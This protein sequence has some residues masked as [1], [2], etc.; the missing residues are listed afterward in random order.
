[1]DALENQIDHHA[2]E[3]PR[4]VEVHRRCLEME[5]LI[6]LQVV[7]NKEIEARCARYA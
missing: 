5:A 4:V 3:H 7:E 1:L 2:N 6:A